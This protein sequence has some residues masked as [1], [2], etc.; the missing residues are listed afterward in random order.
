MF[1]HCP[2]VPPLVI[3]LPLVMQTRPG[4]VLDCSAV[5]AENLPARSLAGV[6]LGTDSLAAESLGAGSLAGE[7]LAAESLLA[8]S[9]PALELGVRPSVLQLGIRSDILALGVGSVCAGSWTQI[10]LLEKIYLIPLQSG[11]GNLLL[12]ANAL[13]SSVILRGGAQNL[14]LE[15]FFTTSHLIITLKLCFPPLGSAHLAKSTV[16]ISHMLRAGPARLTYSVRAASMG[17]GI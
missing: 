7:P 14:P 11:H 13:L 8:G 16:S 17:I 2:I 4:N 9:A 5:A 12:G 6:S 3:S 10:S 15:A 1:H